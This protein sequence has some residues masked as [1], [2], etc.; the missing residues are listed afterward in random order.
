MYYVM[1][2][3]PIKSIIYDKWQERSDWSSAR[4]QSTG[5]LPNTGESKADYITWS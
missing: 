3:A 5:I 2:Y 1:Y 4:G